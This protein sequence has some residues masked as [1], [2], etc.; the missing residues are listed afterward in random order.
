MNE[1]PGKVEALTE[2]NGDAVAIPVE[3]DTRQNE[4]HV[5]EPHS[6]AEDYD[7]GDVHGSA[8][9]SEDEAYVFDRFNLLNWKDHWL[10]ATRRL[11]LMPRMECFHGY[12]HIVL[13]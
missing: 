6:Q 10:S 7:M 9:G 8:A 11:S 13:P 1:E 5:D 3:E 4:R 2:T 12:L